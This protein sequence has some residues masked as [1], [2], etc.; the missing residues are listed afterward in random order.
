MNELA[1]ILMGDE[2]SE[3]SK[4]IKGTK[5]GAKLAQEV[6]KHTTKLLNGWLTASPVFVFG[7]VKKY[8]RN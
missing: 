6:A 4:I 7:E 3:R 8:W 1:I 2:N 5:K